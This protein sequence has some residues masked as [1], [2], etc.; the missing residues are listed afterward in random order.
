MTERPGTTATGGTALQ[1]AL[2][3]GPGRRRPPSWTRSRPPARRFAAGGRIE[4][5][6]LADEVGVNRVTLY[7]WVGSR[8]Q[9]ITE[10]LWSA[11]QKSF[12][13]YRGQIADGPRTAA[14]LT[15]FVRDVN[16][17]SGMQRLLHDEPELALTLLTSASGE[18]ECR[19]LALV[20][21][22]IAEDRAAGLMSDEVPLDDLAYAAV[23]ITESYIHTR[24]I[25]GEEPDAERAGTVLRA[26]LR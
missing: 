7:R 2:G 12:E 16:D 14:A 10:I 18:Y 5:Q 23:R 8:E 15:M 19:Y 20:R 1:R 21:D 24:V 3:Q 26:L 9:L 22:L 17:H 6:S 11:T 13:A 25:T 4:M